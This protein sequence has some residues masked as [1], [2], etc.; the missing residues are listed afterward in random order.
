MVPSFL[1]PILTV[2]L[3]PEVGPVA[4]VVA[5]DGEQIELLDLY[6]LFATHG[7]VTGG[8]Q[9]PLC[10]ID[11]A[12]SA[13]MNAFLKPLLEGAGYR[14]STKLKTGEHAAVVLTM[15]EEAVQ[16]K[17]GAPVVQLRRQRAAGNKR[18][19]SVYRYDRDG[20]LAALATSAGAR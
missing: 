5:I 7:L 1:A 2:L 6:W 16:A 3:E 13:W 19:A 20:L 9:P 8:A 12:D 4:G 15:N 17:N 10:L 14:V 18:E 11:G